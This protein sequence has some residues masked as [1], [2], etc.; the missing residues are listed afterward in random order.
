MYILKDLDHPNI[1]KL[2]E[3]FKDEKYYYLITEYDTLVIRFLT[4]GELFDRIQ[5]LKNFS[6]MDAARIMK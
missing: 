1:V 5:K 2:I 3:L 4:G 6:E